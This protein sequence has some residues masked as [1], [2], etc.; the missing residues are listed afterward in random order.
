MT[1]AHF[2]SEP[3]MPGKTCQRYVYRTTILFRTSALCL[4]LPLSLLLNYQYKNYTCN[5]LC[6]CIYIYIDI[7]NSYP[8]P[9]LIYLKLNKCVFQAEMP[10]TIGVAEDRE[11]SMETDDSS[12]T[13]PNKK[14]HIDTVHLKV[15][16]KDMEMTTFLKDGMGRLWF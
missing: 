2:P 14:Y 4:S 12:I 7:I 11:V 10:S 9:Y 16:R 6:V 1:L 5:Y 3:V 8:F 13:K 15:P